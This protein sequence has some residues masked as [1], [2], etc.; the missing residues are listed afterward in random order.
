MSNKGRVFAII[1]AG[2]YSKRMKTA[3]PKQ[4]TKLGHKPV[5]AYALDVFEQCP[6]VDEIVLV[7]NRAYLGDFRNLVKKYGYSKVGQLCLGGRTRQQSVFNALTTIKDCEYVIIHDGVRPLVSAALVLGVLAAAQR[8]G[9]ATCAVKAVD[10]ITETKDDFIGRIPP[11]QRLW[12]IQT[13]Q[14]FRFD[15][16][17]KAHLAARTKKLFNASDDAQ[18]LVGL[19][20]RVKLVEGGYQNIKLTTPLDRSVLMQ[21]LRDKSR[22]RRCKKMSRT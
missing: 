7:V 10:T 20:Q 17:L 22:T 12:Q 2:G 13:P 9:A 3:I 1:L 5:L 16:I 4:L 18:L 19:K 8:F 21:M 11:R 15:L 14:G 6:A